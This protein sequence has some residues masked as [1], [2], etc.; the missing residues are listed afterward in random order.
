MFL[1][2]WDMHKYFVRFDMR[3][4]KLRFNFLEKERD[5]GG[6]ELYAFLSY[7]LCREF[8]MSLSI[9]F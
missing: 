6:G 4:N 9:P 7:I 5:E 2:K 1:L 3:R 8:L